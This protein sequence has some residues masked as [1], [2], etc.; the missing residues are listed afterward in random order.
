MALTRL[1]EYVERNTVLGRNRDGGACPVS[2]GPPSTPKTRVGLAATPATPATP[3]TMACL[4]PSFITRVT[5]PD[6]LAA[7]TTPRWP[8]AFGPPNGPPSPRAPRGAPP[9]PAADADGTVATAP[10]VVSTASEASNALV[11]DCIR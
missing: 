8:I 5:R 2:S 9:P 4:L 6:L 10:T 7:T 3:L 11:R 1:P